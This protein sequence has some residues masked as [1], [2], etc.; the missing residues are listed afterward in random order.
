MENILAS[1][2][3]AVG[4]ILGLAFLG[5]G[6]GLGILGS[7]MAEAIGRNPETKSDIIQGVMVVAIVLT[8]LLLLLFALVFMLLFF[9]PLLS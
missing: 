9:N 7:K 4:L 2:M 5:T 8:I 3:T 1:T 6:I